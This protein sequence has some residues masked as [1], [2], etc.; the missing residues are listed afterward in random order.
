MA[1]STIAVNKRIDIVSQRIIEKCY[2]TTGVYDFVIEKRSCETKE[3]RHVSNASTC[4][5]RCGS[6]RPRRQTWSKCAK[7]RTSLFPPFF[8]FRLELHE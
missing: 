2:R 3:V 6:R 8:F 1:T 7:M 4:R 5:G